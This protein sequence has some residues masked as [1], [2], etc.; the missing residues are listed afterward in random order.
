[1]KYPS[2]SVRGVE[3]ALLADPASKPAVDSLI[4]RNS[5]TLYSLPD[6]AYQL[7]D[8]WRSPCIAG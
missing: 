6:H 8:S 2:F 3:E 1:M 7:F 5:E 4:E